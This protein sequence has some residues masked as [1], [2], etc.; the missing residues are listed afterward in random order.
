MAF[1]TFSEYSRTNSKDIKSYLN[2]VVIASNEKINYSYFDSISNVFE[3]NSLDND[4]PVIMYDTFTFDY[5]SINES[6]VFTYG[7][8]DIPNR[9]R[10][11][12][13]L[14]ENEYIPKRVND[15]KNIKKIK[16]PIIA[17][18]ETFENRYK[19]IGKL[20]KSENIYNNFIEDIV[21]KTRFKAIIL[22]DSPIC[23][24]E[25]I[26]KYDIDCDLRKFKYFNSIKQI[27]ESLHSKYNLDFYSVKLIES[28]NGKIYL[29][30]IKGVPQLNPYQAVK[31]YEATYND[32][33][34]SRFPNWVK[35]K[36]MS[37]SVVPYFKKKQYD[38]MLI[39]SNYAIDY[40]KYLDNDN[41]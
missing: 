25:T 32:F 29:D 30:K 37:E 23:L 28:N 24:Q 13:D 11:Y 10:I 1:K 4:R 22:K 9:D 8:H 41:H 7:V 36:I 39:K 26:N 33:Y 19:T 17:K 38:N 2:R 6:E 5:S 16:F 3:F 12:S 34:R 20:K 31:V 35:Q 27:A 14:L 15:I 18:N 21:P 40:S